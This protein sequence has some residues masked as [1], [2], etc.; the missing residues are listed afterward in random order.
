MK[1]LVEGEKVKKI[2]I[3]LTASQVDMID[4][5]IKEGKFKNRSEV[6]RSRLSE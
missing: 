6:I 5:M 4:E 2:T 1:A 3:S